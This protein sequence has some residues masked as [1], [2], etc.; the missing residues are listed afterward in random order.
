MEMPDL[1]IDKTGFTSELEQR[2]LVQISPTPEPIESNTEKV[3]WSF[4]A[5]RLA[6]GL[7][8]AGSRII[9]VALAS[10]AVSA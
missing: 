7:A 3:R 6:G 5:L 1:G 8:C 2:G 10:T 4:E 9:V